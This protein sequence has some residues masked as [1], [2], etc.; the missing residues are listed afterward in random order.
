MKRMV[1]PPVKRFQFS[2]GEMLAVTLLLG[3]LLAFIHTRDG[4]VAEFWQDFTITLFFLAAVGV[5]AYWSWRKGESGWRRRIRAACIVAA[6]LAFAA[7]SAGTASYTCWRC[8]AHRADRWAVFSQVEETDESRRV[9]AIVG[10]P[11]SHTYWHLNTSMSFMT[12]TD[13]FVWAD[14]PLYMGNYGVETVVPGLLEKIPD[15]TWATAAIDA[16]GDRDNCLKYAALLVIVDLSDKPPQNDAEWQTWW[17]AAK[18]VFQRTTS[19]AT[20]LPIAQAAVN[21]S[22]RVH[23][24][25]SPGLTLVGQRLSHILP[26]LKVPP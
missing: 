22:I 15:R 12:I 21:D 1:C 26:G 16:M 5:G 23:G 3:G 4:A 2:L 25:F 19:P 9:A 7:L 10:K 20:A 13:S 18:P 17:Q 6:V 11:C 24:Q 14:V 8:G